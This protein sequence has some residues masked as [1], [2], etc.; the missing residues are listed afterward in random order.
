MGRTKKA[1]IPSRNVNLEYDSVS[2]FLSAVPT[3]TEAE[4][5]HGK[6]CPDYTSDPDWHGGLTLDQARAALVSGTDYATAIAA[7]KSRVS[8]RAMAIRPVSDYITYVPADASNGLVLSVAAA[9]AGEPEHWLAPV[10]SQ[11]V[12]CRVSRLIVGGNMLDDQTERDEYLRRG[13]AVIAAVETAEELGVSVELYVAC[14]HKRNNLTSNISICLH[15]AGEPLDVSRVAFA[16]CSMAFNRRLRFAL[17]DK[18]CATVGGCANHKDGYG[19]TLGLPNRLDAVVIQPISCDPDRADWSNDGAAAR[20]A[21]AL[22]SALCGE[23][24]PQC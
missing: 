24:V 7:I 3:Q 21:C 19:R 4:K 23:G 16:L 2:E 15:R 12:G 8:A 20:R 13:A 22:V 11:G 6:D 17:S 10:V 9:A 1:H 18:I 5:L 14:G